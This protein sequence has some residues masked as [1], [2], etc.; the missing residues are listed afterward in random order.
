LAQASRWSIDVEAHFVLCFDGQL[1]ATLR[2]LG[3]RVDIVGDVRLSRP[4]QVLR[5]RWQFERLLENYPT[6]AVVTQSEWSH[7]I[8]APPARRLGL[9]TVLWAH[10][11]ASAGPWIT[12]LAARHRPDWIV[13]N[14]LYTQRA[15]ARF[16]PSVPSN[17]V[18][19]PIAF[20]DHSTST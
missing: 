7:L 9:P 3:A 18:Y 4:Q 10:D 14:S 13:C 12:R 6:D 17:V 5:A 11:A 8:F 1:A 2:G 20:D 15:I 16:F 19:Y